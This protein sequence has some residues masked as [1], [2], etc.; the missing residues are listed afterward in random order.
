MAARGRIIWIASYPKSGNTWVRFMLA[1]VLFG[2]QNSTR[3][4]ENLI[5]DLHGHAD[6]IRRLLRTRPVVYAK[7]HHARSREGEIADLA[8]RTAGFVY[9]VRHPLDVLLSNLNYRLL[10]A[11]PD[12][13]GDDARREAF[14]R[15]YVETFISHGGDPE[16]IERGFGS[17]LEHVEGWTRPDETLKH[18]IVRYE[19]L[20]ADAP[21]AARRICEALAIPADDV[22]LK[23]AVERSSFASMKAIEEREIAD[24]TPGFF[25]HPELT[26]G[27]QAGLRFMNRGEAGTAEKSLPPDEAEAARQRFEPILTRFGYS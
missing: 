10:A 24:R 15:R 11:P 6:A 14:R 12:V 2:P 18:L 16:W 21:A 22:R 23:M 27:H 9:I 13:L 19:D 7:S 1:N 3:N 5:P 8:S 17:L 25:Y 20:K 4:L 26:A